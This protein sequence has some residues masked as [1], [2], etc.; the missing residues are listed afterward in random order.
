MQPPATLRV[1]PPSADDTP[2]F[3]PTRVQEIDILPPAGADAERAS[4]LEGLRRSAPPLA[5][6]LEEA[7]AQMPR[8]GE[9]LLGFEL[10]GLLG[11]GAF[12]RVFLA[13]Q[14]QLSD[15]LV[16]LKVSPAPHDEPRT[17][18][19]L[20]HTNIVPVY[21]VHHAGAL[22][23]VC[24]PY[25]G[26]TT[27]GDVLGEMSR[28]SG[29]LPRSGREMLSTLFGH[30]STVIDGRPAAGGTKAAHAPAAPTP[31]P[32]LSAVARLSHADAALWV[33]A[34]LA[35][36]LAHAHERGVL[37]LDLKPA[38]VLLCDDGLPMLLD[39]NLAVDLGAA[40]SGGARLGGTLPY[41]APEHLEAFL[42][43]ARVVDARSDL[44]ALGVILFEMLTGAPPF[45]RHTGPLREAGAAML[46]DRRRG[47]PS[48]RR[49]NPAVSGAADAIV[50][51]LLAPDQARRYQSAAELR[52]DLE[53]QLAH[54]PLRFAP[55]RS[56]SERFRKWRRRHPRLATAALVGAA[57]GLLLVLPATVI[58]VR[59]NQLAERRLQVE[60]AE[61]GQ[62]WRE[63]APEARVAQALLATRSGDRALI[64]Q[65]LERGRM[66]L[67]RYGL[68]DDPDWARR[69]LF[70]RLPGALQAEVRQELGELLLLMTR[71]EEL[72]AGDAA[73]RSAG[74]RAALR[75][76]VLAEEC[77][78][79]GRRPRLLARQRTG[80]LRELP[81]EAA[82]VAA[83]GT[84]ELD[85]FHEGVES[86]TAGHY[87][88]A[89]ARLQP[90]TEGRPKH[91]LAWFARGV[92]HE[93]LG[94]RADAAACWTACVALEPE[95]PWP[96]FNRGVVRLGQRDHRRAADDFS[97]A[98]RLRP[99]WT[100]ALLNRAIARKWLKDYTGAVA[101]LDAL[102]EADNAPTRALFLR[103]EVKQLAGDAEGAERD[104]AAGMRATPD[105]ELSWSTRGYARMGREPAAALADFD[106]ALE[107]NRR[108]RDALLNKSIVLSE[109]LNRPREAV[110][111][112]DRLL[113]C[114]PEN[115][116][117]RA[118]R[119]VVLARMGEC[120]RA[121]QDAADC[122][123]QER[124]PF[125]LFQM[126]GL[127][128]QLARHE[129]ELD[130]KH[131]SLRLLGQALRSGFGDLNLLNTDTDLEPIR[132][133]PEYRRL[134]TL[135]AELQK[136]PR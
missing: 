64:A 133:D 12:A 41:M 114:D 11:Q 119:G 97:R 82:E 78:P 45:P 99:G 1:V 110:E 42:G 136:P 91:F 105:D 44:F 116:A 94:E 38:N 134:L 84:P 104:R 37:H 18:A 51:K 39:F 109:S 60:A 129:K 123:R 100:D 131:E 93:A 54:R 113:E 92:C 70:I 127:Y 73:D 16:A 14:P 48:A 128:A 86:A 69:P 77:Y 46:A 28:K 62:A 40:S 72:R 90:F 120:A 22:Q 83:D 8:P 52:E 118:G 6:R 76:N 79:P 111:V 96:Y 27:L 34:R 31:A 15:R 23:A 132:G 101:D 43:G 65:G 61:A 32:A 33:A 3:E 71:A 47:S 112:L 50:R 108:S 126:A 21:S 125:L 13:K 10:V 55:D 59:Q 30:H 74:L 53:R 103:A 57:S 117:A 102:L 2:R 135:A 17:L 89:L 130:A 49:R 124:T 4:L 19:R 80:L 95:M 107:L 68:G 87:R 7:A 121:R 36:G 35:D 20:Q 29:T 67:A 122:L 85:A 9:R 66:V 26:G 5:R 56:P 58:A 88:E 98:V 106:R 115:H 25:L 63:V 24:M 81:G 75:W